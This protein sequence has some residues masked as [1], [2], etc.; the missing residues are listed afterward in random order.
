MLQGVSMRH[1]HKMLRQAIEREGISHADDWEMV[2]TRLLLKMSSY[3]SPDVRAGDSMDPRAYVKIKK[4]PGG[5]ISQ[6]EYVDGIVITQNLADKHMARHL[7]SPRIMLLTFPLDYHRVENQFMSLEP[8]LAQE[9]NYLKHLTKRVIDLRPHVV[10]VERSVSRLALDFLLEA[11]VAVARGV[12][13]SGIHQVARC[14]QAD[15]ITSMDKLALEPRLGRCTEF[16]LQTFEHHLIPGFRKTYMRF[17]GC[18]SE[19][20]CTLIVRGADIETLK[21]VKRVADVMTLAVMNMKMEACLFYD[22]FNILPPV[23]QLEQDKLLA[24]LDPSRFSSLRSSLSST[25]LSPSDQLDKDGQQAIADRQSEDIAKSLRPYLET[26]LSTSASVKYPL[27]APLARMGMLDHR[28]RMLRRQREEEEAALILEEERKP[29]P[30]SAPPSFLARLITPGGALSTTGSDNWESNTPIPREPGTDPFSDQLPT[31]DTS[32][33]PIG[34]PAARESVLRSP[35]EVR[36]DSDIAQTE[37]EHAEQLK[38]W[39]WYNSRSAPTV[40]PENYQGL[41]YLDASVCEGQDKPC[42]GP[43]LMTHNFYMEDDCTLGQYIEKLAQSAGHECKSKTCS[44]LQLYHFRVL[45]HGN[46]RLQIAMDQFPCPSPGMEDKIITWSYCQICKDASPTAILRDDTWNFSWAKYLEHSFYPPVGR[47]G[48]ACPHDLYRDQIRYFAH[49]DMAIRI[50]NEVID[51]H[52]VIRPSVRLQVRKETRVLLKNQ[53]YETIV[54][55][56]TA[57]YDSVVLRLKSFDCQVVQPEHMEKLGMQAEQLIERAQIHRSDILDLLDRTYKLT[58]L[59]DVLALNSVYQTLQDSVVQWDVDFTEMEKAYLPSDKDLRRITTANLKRFFATQEMGGPMDRSVSGATVSEADETESRMDDMPAVL[60][61]GADTLLACATASIASSNSSDRDSTELPALRLDATDCG[62]SAATTPMAELHAEPTPVDRQAKRSADDESENESDSTISALPQLSPGTKRRGPATDESSASGIERDLT[63][64]VSRL[65]R[66]SKPAPSVADLIS[67]F[68]AASP[69]EDGSPHRLRSQRVSPVSPSYDNLDAPTTASDR[70]KLRRGK[71]DG[72]Y[73]S[74]RSST[75]GQGLSDDDRS[76]AANAS[77]IPTISAVK[78]TPSHH[79]VGL[80]GDHS[81]LPLSWAHH[82]R[83]KPHRSSTLQ[84]PS[85][86]HGP[87]RPCTPTFSSKQRADMSKMGKGKAPYRQLMDP[88]M[89]S[90]LQSGVRTPK[91]NLAANLSTKVSTLAKHFDRISRDAERDRQ[92][93]I[94]SARGRRAR[95]VALT[96]AK[97][98]VYDNVNDAFRDDDE[99][100]SDGADDEDDDEPERAEGRHAGE[101]EP[102]NLPVEE[103]APAALVIQAPPEDT[104]PQALLQ[105][106]GPTTPPIDITHEEVHKDEETDLLPS[107]LPVSEA[108]TDISLKDRLQIVLPPLNTTTPLMSVPPTPNLPA[109]KEGSGV[110]TVHLSESEVSSGGPE[111]SNILKTLSGLWAY[112]NADMTPLE[113]PL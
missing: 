73:H 86:S 106:P 17:E 52:D 75:R 43:S 23:P 100:E 32:A 11:K 29:Q 54:N 94:A 87:S 84:V 69:T 92:R 50:H 3:V 63:A 4:I 89:K 21:K 56:A 59:T 14:T 13:S 28:L 8:L 76:Y 7:I 55:K 68:Q 111:R 35:E 74:H 82:V 15:V 26:V 41:L 107:S 9:R 85:G 71:T 88:M 19:Y 36:R 47:G 49:R 70:P 97:V 91:R 81:P 110:A 65:P 99:D 66:R 24:E 16:R 90:L 93:R 78:R 46:T 44:R 62:K 48:F 64:F 113:Y 39:A 112:N 31:A 27:P 61:P 101:S 109:S 25:P 10:L 33:P 67:R 96:R 2:L 37:F 42:T 51:I 6:S 38:L 104:A 79:D 57:F 98:S 18:H 105:D 58:P 60:A 108:A 102:E 20:G 45:V 80:S 40:R 1:F 12:K 83:P 95:P 34:P 5:K 103:P 53:E 22:E 72:Y 30:E 77:R